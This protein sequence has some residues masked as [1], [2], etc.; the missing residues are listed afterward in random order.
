M[1]QVVRGGLVPG[2]PLSAC[3][4]RNPVDGDGR[5]DRGVGEWL[6]Q[7]GRLVRRRAWT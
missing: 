6:V 5:T 1:P 4:N 3:R 7:T 2:Q